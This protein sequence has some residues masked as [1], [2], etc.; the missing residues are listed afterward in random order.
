MDGLRGCIVVLLFFCSAVTLQA[1]C[2]GSMNGAEG[3]NVTHASF[4]PGR[5]QGAKSQEERIS[6]LMNQV[7]EAR[8][9]LKKARAATKPERVEKLAREIEERLHAIEKETRK[10]G[11]T[12]GFTDPA[13][14]GKME[15]EILP[16]LQEIQKNW[17][18]FLSSHIGCTPEELASCRDDMKDALVK[19]D[20]SHCLALFRVIQAR[21]G[22]RCFESAS[23][24]EARLRV[25]LQEILAL[26]DRAE[27]VGPLS[28]SKPVSS[29][30]QV[31]PSPPVLSKP[32]AFL[33]YVKPR[34]GKPFPAVIQEPALIDLL[35]KKGCIVPRDLEPGTR[36]TLHYMR[37]LNGSMGMPVE[38]L[39]ALDADLPLDEDGLLS[40]KKTIR[41]RIDGLEKR[42][43][44]RRAAA[45]SGGVKK[46][47]RE[48]PAPAKVSPSEAKRSPSFPLLKRFPPEKG[49]GAERKKQIERKKVVLGVF[50]DPEEQA[51][52]DHYE[53]WCKEQAVR[54]AERA[55]G[56]R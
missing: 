27:Q 24:M 18:R 42:E 22:A 49:W 21:I 53:A 23:L 7:L 34:R 52:L 46:T 16:A 19:G 41:R 5:S 51:F 39:Q 47:A 4:V 20:R 38:D 14:R 31:K 12:G 33:V 37:G 13:C 56:K 2:D 9:Y 29:E 30:K 1:G 15:E 10:G 48:N 8:W 54:E 44:E 36:V 25:I 26:R 32:K 35:L 3:K 43:R 17:G 45:A 55:R 11:G 28:P 50:P 40:V 6:D